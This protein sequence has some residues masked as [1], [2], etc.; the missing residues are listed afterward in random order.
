[1]TY[2]ILEYLCCGG[3][4]TRADVMGEEVPVDSAM[5]G[6]LKEGFAMWHAVVEDLLAMGHHVVTIVDPKVKPLI[7]QHGGFSQQDRLILEAFDTSIGLEDNWVAAA[8]GVDRVVI[9]APEI[10]GVLINLVEHLRKHRRVVCASSSHFLK[11]TSDKWL[12]HRT[13]ANLVKQPR[14]WLAS[15]I[16]SDFSIEI[17][18]S[19]SFVL[20]PRDGAGGSGC[21]QARTG[22]QVSDAVRLLKS[23]EHW[24]VQEWVQGKHCS[25]ALIVDEDGVA[26]VLGA[27]EQLLSIN[28]CGIK[29]KGARGPLAEE[30]DRGLEN[31]CHQILSLIPGVFGWIGIDYL[32]TN[33]DNLLLSDASSSQ[34]RN[35]DRVFIEINPRLTTSY[36]LYRKVYGPS[37]SES[38]FGRQIDIGFLKSC[39]TGD[40]F[41]CIVDSDK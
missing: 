11:M 41:Q 30:V 5:Q 29:Y 35:P 27:T 25:A 40:Q 21:I 2:A 10:D 9:V 26:H 39:E 12:T 36:L 20:K 17:D 38:L 23:P 6:L 1:M 32:I 7:E 37:L 31:W 34:P 8:D 22:K 18:P 24:L 13:L 28:D 19:K 3:L 16:A 15:E 33:P 14:T 4:V